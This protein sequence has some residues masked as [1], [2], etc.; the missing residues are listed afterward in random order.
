VAADLKFQLWEEDASQAYNSGRR[1]R[2]IASIPSTPRVPFTSLDF[3]TV[4]YLYTYLALIDRQGLLSVYEPT[5]ADEMKDWTLLD[6]FHV[7]SPVPGRG[8]ETSFKLQWDHNE[9][10][11][12]YTNSLSDDS[13]QLSLI[14]SSMQDV[15][16]FCSREE[17]DKDNTNQDPSRGSH[18]LTFHECFH[19]PAHPALVRNVAWSSYNIRGHERI[20]TACKDGI[21]RV[22]ELSVVPQ[23]SQ[24]NGDGRSSYGRSS[25]S[26]PQPQSSLTHAITGR[27]GGSGASNGNNARV[28]ELP[29]TYKID[30]VSEL[31]GHG[32][33]WT[34]TWDGT[35][36][37][38]MSGGSDG[39]TRIWRKSIATGKWMLFADQAV[40]FEG[41]DIDEEPES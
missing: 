3:Q 15:K 29:W 12:A 17:S 27:S 38:L 37:I 13:K 2:A 25:R 23:S 18:R 19:L 16:I 24:Q 9:V 36:Q 22:F 28:I 35:G 31:P 14:V 5:S 20:A 21:V 41:D 7:C 40:D 8:D 1:Y 26:R 39:V 4:D 10:P 34:V 33:A 11:L 32:D 30:D 6:Q